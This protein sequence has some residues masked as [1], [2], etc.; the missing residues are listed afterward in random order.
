MEAFLLPYTGLVSCA[1]CCRGFAGICRAALDRN[2]PIRHRGL[3]SFWRKVRGG[4]VTWGRG[5]NPWRQCLVERRSTAERRTRT[6][7]RPDLRSLFLVE[8]QA[9]QRE[10]KYRQE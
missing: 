8:E 5:G 2:I 10:W 4:R 9:G 1:N 7:I 6:R 3:W